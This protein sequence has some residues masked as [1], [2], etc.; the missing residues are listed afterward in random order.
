MPPWLA[1]LIIKLAITLLEK[2]GIFTPL[3]ADAVRAGTHVIKVMESIKTYSS[4]SD[5]PSEVHADGV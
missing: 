3:E 4:P 2:A 5:F 1:P